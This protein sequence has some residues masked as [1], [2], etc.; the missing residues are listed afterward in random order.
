MLPHAGAT[1]AAVVVGVHGEAAA[2]SAVDQ[3]RVT[4]GVLA[5]AVDQLDHRA[6]RGLRGMDVV[7]DRDAVRID[8]L[9]HGAS[10][11]TRARR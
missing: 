6:R 3:P 11:D 7:D 2:V 10:L 9:G 8:E 5:V 1:V 4:S